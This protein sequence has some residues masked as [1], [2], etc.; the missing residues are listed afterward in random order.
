MPYFL[1][2][3]K[4]PSGGILYYAYES[5]YDST[6]KASRHKSGPYLGSHDKLKSEGI[7]DPEAHCRKLIAGMNEAAA[8]KKSEEIT[9][10]PL[11]LMGGGLIFEGLI[12][13]MNFVPTM[14]L[15][16]KVW[17]L[18]FGLGSMLRDLTVSRILH[19]ASKIRTFQE[20]MP[21]I[22]T[23][24][25]PGFT[26]DQMYLG[27]ERLGSDCEGMVEI[28]NRG[29]SGL[30]GKRDTS[31]V[32]F[33]CTNF[34]FE[35]DTEKGMQRRGPSKENRK[36]PI[37]GMALLLDRES[38]PI[39]MSLY[40]GSQSEKPEIRKTISEMKSRNNITGRTIQIADKGLNCGQNI[41]EALANGDGY[42]F[43]QSV[44]G[45]SKMEKEWVLLDIPKEKAP[46]EGLYWHD[47]RDS[48]GNLS[49]Q[50]KWK[51]DTYEI[52]YDD[53][54]TKK[55]EKVVQMRLATYNPSLAS[56]QRRELD[57]LAESARAGCA[58]MMKRREL[59]ECAKYVKFSAA[60]KR[61]GEVDDDMGVAISFDEEAYENDR[62]FCGY[63]M[64][65]T[66]ETK[67]KPTEIYEAYHRLWRIEKCFRVMKT[68]IESRPVYLQKTDS[69]KGHFLVCYLAVLLIRLM[70]VKL[71]GDR[72][73]ED[74]IVEASRS[75][76]LMKSGPK[77][78]VNLSG[79]TKSL[80]KMASVTGHKYLNRYLS[81]SDL[82]DMEKEVC[83]LD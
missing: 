6:K 52:A 30:V 21:G 64:L 51:I 35:I 71:L 49:Y 65:A 66:S 1:K 36:D 82:K 8:T 53:G 4:S 62:M 40:P 46:S 18:Q 55:K 57:R 45:A 78:Y 15:L 31:R 77:E 50:Y 10:E 54:G 59:G 75:F 63:N 38:V 7:D 76:M 69:I 83:T 5:F 13:K 24:R 32:F 29:V 17:G 28:I 26:R 41:H 43:S 14:D 61:T 37:I 42:I 81:E 19:P 34:Y 72:I 48:D 12:S 58:S 47:V 20:V 67:M 16:G 79:R 3:N 22:L 68:Q 33:D 25:E 73:S 23:F 74:E 39:S 2:K 44:K 56:K 27:L 9:E 80:E 60:D 70:Q 11:A